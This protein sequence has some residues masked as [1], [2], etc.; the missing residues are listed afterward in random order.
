MKAEFLNPFVFAG[1]RV[2]MSE[3][4]VSNWKLDKP[5]LVRL[6]TTRH[7]VNVVMGVTGCVQG[8]VSYGMDL[9]VAKEIVRVMAGSA[10]PITDDVAQSAL[11]ELGNMITGLATGILEE[12]GYP[13]RISPPA[14]VRGTAVRLTTASVPMVAVPMQTGLGAIT[15][16]LALVE[17]KAM[18]VQH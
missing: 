14:I 5:Y 13:C 15:I 3:A 4:G 11:G 6:D 12:S 1:M 17:A 9:V 8:I 10:I 7:A 18:P 2:L 16:Y